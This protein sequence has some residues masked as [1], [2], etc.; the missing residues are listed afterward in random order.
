MEPLDIPRVLEVTRDFPPKLRPLMAV[1]GTLQ[2]ALSLLFGEEVKVRLIG[3]VAS[4]WEVEREVE[5][6]AGDR[7]VATARSHIVCTIAQ[8]SYLDD[9]ILG[10]MGIG[11]L[12]TQHGINC[13]AR[14][15]D[16]G[17]GDKEC[18]RKYILEGPGVSITITEY[19]PRELYV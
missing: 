11:Q 12:L 6:V 2:G 16:C 3:Q 5:L 8:Q 4:D 7:V 13:Q 15:M 9:I 17:A 14:L 10:E 19:F 18:W 1:F